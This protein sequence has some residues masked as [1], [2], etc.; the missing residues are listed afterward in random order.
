M[1]SKLDPSRGQAFRGQ[2]PLPMSE[3][4]G[5]ATQVDYILGHSDREIRRLIFQAALLRPITERLMRDAGI[6]P[7][8]RV[9]DCGCG[10]GDVSMLA[11]ELVGGSGTVVGIDRSRAAI[12]VAEERARAAGLAQVS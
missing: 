6:G 11:A 10:A 5:G 8:M 2:E 1:R 9:L 12:G 3:V 4:T 7:G